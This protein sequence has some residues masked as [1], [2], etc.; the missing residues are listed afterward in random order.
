MIHEEILYISYRKYQLNFWL[1][2]RMIKNCIWT[3]LK[4]IFPLYF[5]LH[6]TGFVV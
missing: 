3:T 6:M 4:V 5:N 1:V 2:I